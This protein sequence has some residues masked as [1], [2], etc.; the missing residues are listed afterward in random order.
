M[1]KKLYEIEESLRAL[2]APITVSDLDGGADVP[3]TVFVCHP[4]IEE[5]PKRTF[6]SIDIRLMDM[7]F[8][9]EMEGHVP[10]VEVTNIDNATKQV[11]TRKTAHWYRLSYQIHAWSLY[12]IQDRDLVR[13]IENRISPRDSLTVAGEAFWIFR[14]QFNSLDE[15]YADRMIY[16]KV[17]T[18]EILA[19]ID[20]SETDLTGRIVDEI[21][22]QSNSIQTRADKGQLRPVTADGA[23]T[24]ASQA[25]RFLHREF[26]FNDQQ[27][28][29]PQD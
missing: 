20:N 12:A 11:T 15:T 3:I 7:V 5:V 28:W 22:I 25:Q 26:R 29:F 23:I 8:D 21:Y 6:P 4:D 10:A 19:D 17:W 16:H 27:F 24:T 14:D 9:P 18:Y 1:A 2:Y 13:R